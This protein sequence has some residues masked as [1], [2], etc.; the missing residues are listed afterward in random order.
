MR[1]MLCAALAALMASGS[2]HATV[3]TYSVAGIF[4]DGSTLSG[5]FAFDNEAVGFARYSDTKVSISSIGSL[6]DIPEALLT[7][8]TIQAIYFRNAAYNYVGIAFARSAPSFGDVSF[9]TQSLL[10]PSS[11]RIAGS[12]QS[13][14]LTSGS[15]TDVTGAVPEPASWAMM[16]AGFGLVGGAMR[17]RQIRI[18]YAV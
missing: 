14:A 4:E 16:I 8:Q 18:S 2:A 10:P 7:N 6:L 17:R 3:F 5:S 12:N 9:G 11:Y 1:M 13:F 15:I